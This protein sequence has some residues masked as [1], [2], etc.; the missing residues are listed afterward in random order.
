MDWS[1]E[2]VPG[3]ICGGLPCPIVRGKGLGGSSSI[4]AM[5][6]FRG[7]KLDY[8]HWAQMGNEG[9]D[10][11]HVLPYFKK[12]EHNLDP[13]V[14]KDTEYH[15]VDGYLS[16]GRFTFQGETVG[17]LTEAFKEIGYTEVDS[18]GKHQSGFMIAQMTQRNSLRQST[19][20]AFLEPILKRRPNLKIVTNV[21]VTKIL[22]NESNM[23]YGVQYILEKNRHVGGKIFASR[24]V[25]VSAGVV[26][27]PQL[28]MLSGIGPKEVLQPLSIPVMKDLK[29]GE[30]LQD[31]AS[32][33]G[34]FFTRPKHEKPQFS[35]T[36]ILMDIL[37]YAE[38]KR[39]G[40]LT[41]TELNQVVAYTNTK[42]SNSSIDY[43]D[44]MI[45][46]LDL[47]AKTQSE[48]DKVVFLPTV[49]RPKSRG[50]ITIN[51]TDPFSSPLIHQNY[52]SEPDDI[53]IHIDIFN[54]AKQLA[55][56][57]AMKNTGY[58][59]NTTFLPTEN[60]FK[61]GK[62]PLW[63]HPEFLSQFSIFHLCG[64]CKM[65]PDDDETAVVDPSLR[66]RGIGKLRVVDASIM[67]Y[68]VSGNINAPTI[69]VAEKG[70][71]LIKRY[72]GRAHDEIERA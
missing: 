48:T 24:E 35:G 12:S 30:N 16:V 25:I 72:W 13:D 59:L 34:V 66:V 41:S 20:R 6:Y 21:R 40:P 57:Y 8:D 28:L 9:W 46:F 45:F 2:G 4:N 7:N 54:V 58:V 53:K 56:T 68:I 64:T 62:N 22:I 51:T 1:Y 42:Y 32:T 18:N 63:R 71:D 5:L 33:P 3:V 14:R 11:E 61:T 52:F 69:M 50:K 36:S 70:A 17:R 15:G 29:V 60:D 23:A 37:N 47:A 19:N 10:F 49:L 67:P 27:S 55:E 31:H 39:H 65:G 38:P 43:P 26:N 44:A